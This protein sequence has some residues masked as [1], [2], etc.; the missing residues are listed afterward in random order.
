MQRE[1]HF[2]LAPSPLALPMSH[3]S[4][5]A[6]A[7]PSPHFESMQLVRHSALCALLF[8]VP[9]SHCSPASRMPLPQTG[10][11]GACTGG[12]E[13]ACCTYS[14]T[15]EEALEEE[16]VNVGFSGGG[17]IAALDDE[18][19]NTGMSGFIV[20][21]RTKKGED[22]ELTGGAACSMGGSDCTGTYA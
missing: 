7:M 10:S 20:G 9:R 16:M 6:S 19:E 2:V 8:A 12:C 1:V 21:G 22:E 13:G 17:T 5:G 14:V 18:E 11:M 3:S 15:V 4:Y